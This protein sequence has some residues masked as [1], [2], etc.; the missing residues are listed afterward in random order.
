MSADLIEHLKVHQYDRKLRCGC[1]DDG[2]YVFAELDGWRGGPVYDCY[3]S[4]GVSNEES[5]TRDFVDKYGMNEYNSFAFD[6]T[7]AGYP[8]AY[9]NKIS[10][11]RKNIGIVNDDT[12]TNL[13]HLMDKYDRIF[14]KMDIEGGEYPWLLSLTDAQ[15]DRFRQIVI[16]FHGTTDDSWN[17]AYSDKV[18]CMKKLAGTHYVVHAHG[19]NNGPWSQG[20]PHVLELT[21]V[22]K[23]DFDVEPALNTTPLPIPG[24][25]FANYAPASDMHI[26][27]P[28]FVFPAV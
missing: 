6:G 20:I 22:N 24:L 18:A 26:S 19:N 8:Y 3:I 13:S 27:F 23:R 11:I 2:G 4:A 14:L 25:D 28:P 7:I 12:Q 16:E 9:T 17:A 5:F 21:Y 15:L 1:N 10:F